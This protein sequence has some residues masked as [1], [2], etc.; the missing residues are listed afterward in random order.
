MTVEEQKAAAKKEKETLA[1]M[2]VTYQANTNYQ[3]EELMTKPL[4][5]LQEIYDTVMK[6]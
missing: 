6:R 4:K 5:R 1:K 2:I 3:L